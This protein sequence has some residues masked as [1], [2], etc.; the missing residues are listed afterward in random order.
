M[1][2]QAM[3]GN[4]I[5]KP[6]IVVNGKVKGI[7]KRS[8]KKDKIIVEPYFLKSGDVLKKKEMEKALEG[9]RSFMGGELVISDKL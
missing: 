6:I 2:K 8:F 3:S 4:G 1:A 9:Y 5:F 7:W